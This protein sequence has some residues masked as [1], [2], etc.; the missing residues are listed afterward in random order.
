[1]ES[2]RRDILF[3]AKPSSDG[4]D[5]EISYQT[6]PPP[7]DILHPY[8]RPFMIGICQGQTELS[9]TSSTKGVP[10]RAHAC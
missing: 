8:F 1:M 2:F 4:N 10:V 6:G 7:F 9:L 3:L 5:F